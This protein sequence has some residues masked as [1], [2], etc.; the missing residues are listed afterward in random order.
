MAGASFLHCTH[1]HTHTYTYTHTHTYTHKFKHKH[2]HPGTLTHTK[3][4]HMLRYTRKMD[5]GSHPKEWKNAGTLG[6]HPK[7]TLLLYC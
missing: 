7:I 5:D 6:M 4:T 2:P 3:Y 1:P